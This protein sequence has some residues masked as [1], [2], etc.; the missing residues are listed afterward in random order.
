MALGP[1]QVISHPQTTI[2]LPGSEKIVVARLH[3]S[4]VD[5]SRQYPTK[6]Q[7][8]AVTVKHKSSAICGYLQLY[9]KGPFSQEFMPLV[10]G[11]ERLNFSSP[12]LASH[13]A[14]PL[15]RLGCQQ[16]F[17]FI[18]CVNIRPHLNIDHSRRLIDRLGGL[19][20]MVIR[21]VT[22]NDVV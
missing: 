12:R 11:L 10:L 15:L 14:P 19:H 4:V 20:I 1:T 2:S 8:H 16:Y 5:T 17:I 3:P 9:A 21:L 7:G 13:I 6:L 22:T 18:Q